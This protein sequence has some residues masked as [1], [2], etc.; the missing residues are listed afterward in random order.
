MNAQY[1]IRLQFPLAYNFLLLLR[2]PASKNTAFRTLMNNMDVVPLM[3]EDFN[4]YAPLVMV[5]L[6]L[7]TVFHGYARLLRAVGLQHEDLLTVEEHAGRWM[8]Y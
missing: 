1:L 6:A 4:V 3:G 8:D 5:V 2:N 7:F